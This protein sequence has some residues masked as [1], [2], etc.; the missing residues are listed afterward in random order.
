VVEALQDLKTLLHL[1]EGWRKSNPNTKAFTYIQKSTGSQSR[2]DRIYTT[3]QLFRHSYEWKIEN[4]GIPTDHKMIS[5]SV[6][7]Q[8]IATI[9]WKR[10]MG[11]PNKSSQG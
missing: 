5:V 10:K 1:E 4:T 2:I 3:S 7:L 6:S 8:P 11:N 9:Y